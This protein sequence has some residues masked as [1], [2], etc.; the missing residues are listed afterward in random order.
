MRIRLEDLLARKE[1]RRGKET[2]VVADGVVDRETVA[3][4]DDEVVLAVRGRGVN[5]AGAA[6]ERDVLAEHDR[7]RALLERVPEF[8]SFQFGSPDATELR[9]ARQS[10]AGEHRIRELGRDDE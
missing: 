7:H 4:A 2:A 10:C 1:R 3:A 9:R 8:Q 5:C 6:V